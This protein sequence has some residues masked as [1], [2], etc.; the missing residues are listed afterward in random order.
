MLGFVSFAMRVSVDAHAKNGIKDLGLPYMSDTRHAP[1]TF[2]FVFESD[3]RFYAEDCLDPEEWLH[4]AAHKNF[5][6]M[7]FVEEKAEDLEGVER[8]IKVWPGPS[9]RATQRQGQFVSPASPFLP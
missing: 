5:D 3:F 7:A 1:D 6:A 9:S 4:V 8:P 2:F